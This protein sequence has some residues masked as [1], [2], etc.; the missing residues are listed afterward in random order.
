MLV[1]KNPARV[2]HLCS[3]WRNE[4]WRHH[5]RDKLKDTAPGVQELLRSFSAKVAKWRYETLHQCFES[6]L[7]LKDLTQ[8]FLQHI[9][10][11]FNSFQD[12]ALL[13]SVAEFC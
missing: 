2:R 11:M 9:E 7:Q 6:L 12:P 8:Q 3:F 13:K 1:A 10:G 5:I 4:S